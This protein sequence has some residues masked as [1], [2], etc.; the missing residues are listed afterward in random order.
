[1]GIYSAIIEFNDGSSGVQKVLKLVG[2]ENGQFTKSGTCNRNKLRIAQSA[3][4]S[5]D[6]GKKG[7]NLS[8][9]LERDFLIKKRNKKKRW[10]FLI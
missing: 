3:R 9:Q 8:E 7:G 6:K 10:W 5:S 4:K 1:M 2:V